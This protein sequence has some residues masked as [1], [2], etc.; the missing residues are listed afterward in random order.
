MSFA[1]RGGEWADRVAADRA[2]A[3][4]LHLDAERGRW[5]VDASWQRSAV[6]LLPLEAAR[7]G[8]VVA[9][10]TN[11][12]H[13]AAW[14]LDVHG[15]P[16]GAPE[17]FDYD[18]SGTAQHRDAQ[19]R[20]ALTRLLHY[21]R[22]TGAK[23]IA[24]EDLDFA[25]SKTR[26]KHGRNRRF[27]QVISGIPT[28]RLKARLVSMA[29]ECGIAVVAVD[30]AY[31]SVWGVKYWQKPTSTPTRKTTRHEAASLVIGRRALGHGARR[32][33][34]PPPHHRSDGAGHRTVQAERC[35]PGREG[36]RP[37]RKAARMRSVHPPG[38]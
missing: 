21:T 26:E 32:R 14:R 8:G 38:V 4:R 15:N 6:R 20:H 33:T 2:V 18:L 10:D 27:R 37:T 3:Y 16:V 35:V 29:A 13:L 5:Y 34:A 9:V 25:D 7:G 24:V 12:D 31:T 23:A 30:P 36:T 28:S 11:A 17:R 19:V 22:R 1:H